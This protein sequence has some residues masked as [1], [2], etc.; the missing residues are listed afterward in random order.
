MREP[1]APPSS[2]KS[3]T[4]L[5]L[6]QRQLEILTPRAG[7]GRGA[8]WEWMDTFLGWLTCISL[9]LPGFAGTRYNYWNDGDGATYPVPEL[10][11]L[12]VDSAEWV[13][14]ELISSSP[15]HADI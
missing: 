10:A 11:A 13:Q 12:R 2:Q 3:P 5:N 9:L 8:A 4:E 1:K 6:W 7:E 15:P 14:L